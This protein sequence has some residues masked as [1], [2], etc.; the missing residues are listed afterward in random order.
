MVIPTPKKPFDSYKWRW[1]SFQPTEG[2]NEPPVFLGVL[3]VL[4][5]HEGA[6]PSSPEVHASLEALEDRLRGRVQFGGRLA[7]AGR[8]NL[9]RN[10]Q[11]YWKAL[12]V[13]EETSPGI[14]LTPFG[15]S[16]ADGHITRNEFAA[17]VIA[18]LTLPNRRIESSAEAA[19][20]DAVGLEIY[21]LRLLLEILDALFAQD[22]QGRHGYLTA[23]ELVEVV[24]PLA[25]IHATI[26]VFVAAILE[27]RAGRLSQIG[28]ADY[29]P[30]ANDRR[31]AKEFLRFLASYG[32]V[33]QV[34]DRYLADA[35]TST[36]LAAILEIDAAP[37][38]L[39]KAAAE[40]R[41]SPTLLFV[42]RNRV[43]A[44]VLARPQ[45]TE[46]RR[47]VLESYKSTCLLTG[48][49]TPAVLQAAHI[50]PVKNRGPDHE[51]NG[52]CLRSDVHTLFDAGHIRISPKGDVML[53]ELLSESVTY[54]KLPTK[55]KVPK[56]VSEEALKW[57]WDLE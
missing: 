36:E 51:S 53:S 49:Q 31:M 7:R 14:V 46:F 11:Q 15:R 42:E 18:T 41:E 19:K 2:L 38:Q 32:Y 23:D 30:E 21:P 47:K 13:L 9:L 25:G 12:G 6:V 52:V 44:H 20:W 45:Q 39:N 28:W 55:V 3:R 43:L 35:T 56:F 8:R 26:D 27:Y 5:E 33:Q 54:S 10:S 34:G 1:A 48:E 50:I 4:R 40:A 16:V 37:A 57:K 24:I 29:T 17:A 22:A